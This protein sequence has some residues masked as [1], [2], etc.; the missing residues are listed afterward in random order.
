MGKGDIYDVEVIEINRAPTNG[1][2]CVNCH[3][4]IGR[5]N[6]RGLFMRS[7]RTFRVKA[8]LC[9][10]C[11]KNTIEY[12]IN[13]L[14]RQGRELQRIKADAKW[15]PIIKKKIGTRTFDRI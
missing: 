8:Y 12:R 6:P 13:C 9:S 4:I 10:D 3:N 14:V 1:S 15:K 11:L 7:F 5:N 2:C